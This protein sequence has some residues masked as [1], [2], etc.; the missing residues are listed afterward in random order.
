MILGVPHRYL[1]GHWGR[2][3]STTNLILWKGQR[4]QECGEI[5]KVRER[6][7]RSS[8]S[9]ATPLLWEEE[10]LQYKIRL[11]V[12]RITKALVEKIQH[13]GGPLP[14]KVSRQ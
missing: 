9:K 7:P 10:E 14:P 8:L 11:I 3:S 4:E 2:R 6:V 1:S 13:K 12:L 5:I